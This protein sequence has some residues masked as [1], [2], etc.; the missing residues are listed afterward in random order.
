M[1]T[2]DETARSLQ[3][4]QARLEQ[5]RKQAAQQPTFSKA[6]IKRSTK[7]QRQDIAMQRSSQIAEIERAQ[8]QVATQQTTVRNLATTQE[9]ID[10]AE[11][12]FARLDKSQPLEPQISMYTG[13]TRFYLEELVDNNRLNIE[14]FQEQIERL[15]A[16]GEKPVVDWQ[17]LEI[18][19]VESSQ[20]GGSY[21]ID[22]Y[23]QR[24]DAAEAQRLE[25]L[26]KLKDVQ[27]VSTAFPESYPTGTFLF[28]GDGA[29]SPPVAPKMTP[30]QAWE[31]FLF[32]R[33]QAR[34]EA[35]EKYSL[36][37]FKGGLAKDIGN[38]LVSKETLGIKPVAFTSV[39]GALLSPFKGSFS[40]P[41][42]I[43]RPAE[44][45]K[46]RKYIKLA[47]EINIGISYTT[48]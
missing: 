9:A 33:E 44:E 5:L 25:M 8:E 21:D 19:G 41:A 12:I 47:S 13:E 26:N 34:T 46:G 16:T 30:S 27:G 4:Q 10:A 2:L 15:E 1:A 18:I 37:L 17:K 31:D 28:T 3:E 14:A 40:S 11:R 35:V 32:R 38:V 43:K 42:D 48:N 45:Q 23:K 24:I 20:L 39:K 29:Y 22:I 6:Q 7:E 36:G